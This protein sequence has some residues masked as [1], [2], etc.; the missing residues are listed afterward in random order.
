M[1]TVPR[2]HQAVQL[3]AR[4]GRGGVHKAGSAVSSLARA[5]ERRPWR[6]PWRSKR[7]R[8]RPR[9]EPRCSCCAW[10]G[11][12]WGAAASSEPPSIGKHLVRGRVIGL[13]LGLGFGL[14][15]GLGLGLVG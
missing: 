11:G 14:G 5:A 13:G 10:G 2:S 9:D 15:L 3:S 1:V 8:E 7:Q 4:A 6:R 12:A